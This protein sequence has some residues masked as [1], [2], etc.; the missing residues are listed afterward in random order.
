MEWSGS[1]QECPS[2]SR[3]YVLSDCAVRWTQWLVLSWKRARGG[4]MDIERRYH[5][6]IMLTWCPRFM[7]L[8]CLCPSAGHTV[9]SS[10]LPFRIGPKSKVC[11]TPGLIH[12]SMISPSGNP[13]DFIPNRR[14]RDWKN[15]SLWM[16][17][18]QANNIDPLLKAY[19]I[20]VTY[21]L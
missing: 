14:L 1:Q 20:L 17:S 7:S 8:F 15:W 13:E 16:M 10:L 18:Y 5:W 11:R 21:L 4:W 9:S 6:T 2:V 19:L 12:L 3:A